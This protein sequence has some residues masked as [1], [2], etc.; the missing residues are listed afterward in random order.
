MFRALL[1]A[2]A[3][4]AALWATGAAA[5]QASQLRQACAADYQQFCP[6]VQPGGGRILQCMRQHA[7]QLSPDG[8]T[9]LAD[10]AARWKAAQAANGQ[11]NG[12]G[13]ASP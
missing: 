1:F 13:A 7:D 11:S 9:A 6:G 12:A 3:A 8:R 4:L 10:A 2:G 5:Q